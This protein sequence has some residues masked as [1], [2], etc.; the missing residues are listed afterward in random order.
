[1]TKMKTRYCLFVVCEF[2][3]YSIILNQ[4]SIEEHDSII[5]LLFCR[6]NMNRPLL[7]EHLSWSGGA[8]C[9]ELL[10]FLLD[11]DAYK[12]LAAAYYFT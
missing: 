9:L 3:T 11:V 2:V 4:D 5:V 8:W 10:G 12:L 7:I 1:M 6:T